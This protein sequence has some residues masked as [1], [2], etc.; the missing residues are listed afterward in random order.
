[1]NSLWTALELAADGFVIQIRRGSYIFSEIHPF[2]VEYSLKIYGETEVEYCMRKGLKI[3]K[4]V[5]SEKSSRPRLLLSR[6]YFSTMLPDCLV[7]TGVNTPRASVSHVPA[8]QG[9]TEFPDSQDDDLHEI[10]P[11]AKIKVEQVLFAITKTPR[12]LYS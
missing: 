5:K 7:N 4:R 9:P 6:S 8:Q 12:T 11:M 3:Q 2:I 10:P 1:M